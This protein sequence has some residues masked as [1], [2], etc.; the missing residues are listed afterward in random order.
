M[1]RILQIPIFLSYLCFDVDHTA[2]A[3]DDDDGC[4]L[5]VWWLG[6]IDQ[7]ESTALVCGTH[8]GQIHSLHS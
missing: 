3:D 5:L 4:S 7:Q 8:I 6:G 2:A 1:D